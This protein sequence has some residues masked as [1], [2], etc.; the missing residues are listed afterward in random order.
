MRKVLVE[1]IRVPRG[2]SLSGQIALLI[3]MGESQRSAT[4]LLLH[5]IRGELPYRAKTDVCN[6]LH[7]DREVSAIAYEQM[8]ERKLEIIRFQHS[9]QT[10]KYPNNAYSIPKEFFPDGC[11]K[12]NVK[13]SLLAWENRS[14]R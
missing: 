1:S 13:D 3:G 10:L 11:I 8:K 5:V 4:I 9:E 2:L 6:A 12:R 14:S 7:D